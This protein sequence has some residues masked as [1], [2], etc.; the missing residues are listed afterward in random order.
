MLTFSLPSHWKGNS[1]VALTCKE[2]FLVLHMNKVELMPKA[3]FLPKVVSSFHF[4]QHI[5][6][7]S[8]DVVQPVY[9]STTARRN[10]QHKTI[11]SKAMF[12]YVLSKFTTP[13]QLVLHVLFSIRHMFLIFSKIFD[14]S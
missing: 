13:Y 11:Y 12:H 1:L 7:Y 10:C 6:C 8:L 4:N 5:C 9:T 2:L 3:Y 14:F